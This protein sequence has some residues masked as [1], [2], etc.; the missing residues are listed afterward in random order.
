MSLDNVGKFSGYKTAVFAAW[1]LSARSKGID[2]NGSALHS[3]VDC[4]AGL[5]VW[6]VIKPVL[7]F[8]TL[9]DP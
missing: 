3:N 5:F 1:K 8:K 2:R 9:L 7:V 4:V 6:L